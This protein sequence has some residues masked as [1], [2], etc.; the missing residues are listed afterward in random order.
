MSGRDDE[1]D[2][3]DYD[4]DI[5]AAMDEPTP[6]WGNDLPPDE[7][8]PPEVDAPVV[9]DE[10]AA[11]S[12]A[13]S[14][15]DDILGGAAEHA[16]AASEP[17]AP[18]AEEVPPVPPAPQAVAVPGTVEAR[19]DRLEVLLTKLIGGFNAMAAHL[20]DNMERLDENMAILDGKLERVLKNVDNVDFLV[21]NVGQ[22]VDFIVNAAKVLDSKSA[23]IKTDTDLMK[24]DVMLVR[25]RIQVFFDSRE[26]SLHGRNVA[27]KAK[28]G[29][30]G[31]SSTEDI[32][33][34]R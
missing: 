3:S 20:D 14:E 13:L 10:A 15:F 31:T 28:K 25:D 7:E 21:S 4:D 32:F 29:D 23:R 30:S 9:E 11:V 17:K 34:P 6:G 33:A 16:V 12:S 18:D 27:E 1:F 22:D 5:R 26:E 24:K 8:P 19:L 2:G